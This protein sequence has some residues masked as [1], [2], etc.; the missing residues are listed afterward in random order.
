MH[1]DRDVFIQGHCVSGTFLG[2]RKI[3]RRYFVLGHPITPSL[4][5]RRWEKSNVVWFGGKSSYAAGRGGREEWRFNS[6]Y[7]SYPA[8]AGEGGSKY[9]YIL[10]NI[11]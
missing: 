11:T 9:S 10:I 6:F 5:R 7:L 2:P 4:K 1:N 3:V 8:S